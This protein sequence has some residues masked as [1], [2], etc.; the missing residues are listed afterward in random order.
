MGLRLAVAFVVAGVTCAH[1]QQTITPIPTAPSLPPNFPQYK[2][3]A[4]CVMNCDT[5]VGACQG[6]CSLN[7][8]PTFTLAPFA[9][10]APGTGTGTLTTGAASLTQCYMSCTSQALLCKQSCPPVH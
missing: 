4:A 1:A 8:T 2:T 7:N 6:S 3:Y 5:R 9:S 10:T